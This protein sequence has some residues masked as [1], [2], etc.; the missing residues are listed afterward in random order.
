MSKQVEKR[1]Y[2][3]RLRAENEAAT[4]L[5]IT[6]AAVDLHGTLGP[7]KT[8]MSAV[9]KRAGV[10]RATLY[11]HFPDEPA[12]FAACSSHWAMQNP[13]PDPTPWMEVDDPG[14]RL[15]L[16][17]GE[18]YAYYA[19]TEEMTTRIL[20]DAS[21]VPTIQD[22]MQPMLAYLDYVREVLLK[23]RPGARRKK[24]RAAL[25]HAMAFETWR[26]LEREQG[27]TRRDAVDLAVAVV[28]AAS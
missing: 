9:A 19:H 20:R 24:V 13:P 3:K 5:K 4:R 28:D 16:G 17:L 11:R 12:L 22:A 2:E 15:R 27:L 18:L 14:D 8:T 1:K 6:E 21:L 23:G 10:Q 25:G 26:S 7:A